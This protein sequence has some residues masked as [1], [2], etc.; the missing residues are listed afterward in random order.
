MLLVDFIIYLFLGWYFDKIVP[1]EYGIRQPWYFLI[2]P[3][4]WFGSKPHLD[5]INS[6]N[7]IVVDKIHNESIDSNEESPNDEKKTRFEEIDTKLKELV[8]FVFIIIIG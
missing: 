4:Y 6:I 8:Y 3:S 2:S 5:S 7:K 1:K